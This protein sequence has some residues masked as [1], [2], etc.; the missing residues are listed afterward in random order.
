MI[1]FIVGEIDLALWGSVAFVAYYA[2]R[3]WWRTPAGRL[4]MAWVAM[5]AAELGLL[6][7][8]AA[9]GQVPLW[10]VAVVYG[11]IDLGVLWR[12]VALVNAQEGWDH[13][14]SWV[15]AALRTGAQALWGWLVIQAAS[16][17][18]TL[19]D[20]AQNW[21]VETIIVA[22]GIGLVTAALRWLETRKG[23]GWGARV[24]RWV[25]RAAMLGLSARQPVYVLPAPQASPQTVTYADSSTRPVLRE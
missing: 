18:V 25:A 21:F 20:W 16:A 22:G 14:A 2:L 3:P 17:G 23:D 24:A 12:L 1:R 8:V 9:R 4:V 7:L 13:M 6:R 15:Y 5:S 11:V 10:V 19:P